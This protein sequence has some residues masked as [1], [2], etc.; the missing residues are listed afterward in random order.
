MSQCKSAG[1]WTT[2]RRRLTFIVESSY[3]GR[4][5]RFDIPTKVD[6][7]GAKTVLAR[8]KGDDVQG[9]K[10]KKNSGG[11]LSRLARLESMGR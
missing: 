10:V 6:E 4:R 2:R 1:G 5:E 9:S 11:H 3:H 8:Q 7:K